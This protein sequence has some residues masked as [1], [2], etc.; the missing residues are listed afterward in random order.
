MIIKGDIGPTKSH[1][2]ITKYTFSSEI[3][4]KFGK[5]RITCSINGLIHTLTKTIGW[6]TLGAQEGGGTI[7]KITTSIYIYVHIYMCIYI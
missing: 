6:F 5:T 3:C 4:L 7:R 2:F 1:T